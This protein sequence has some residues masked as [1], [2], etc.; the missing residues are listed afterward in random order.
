MSNEAKQVMHYVQEWLEEKRIKSYFDNKKNETQR[1]YKIKEQDLYK[2][3]YKLI[4][5]MEDN[6]R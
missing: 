2:L 5:L 6:I 4:C 3:C 1:Y